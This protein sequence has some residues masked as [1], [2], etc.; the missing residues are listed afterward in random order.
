M[1]FGA[2]SISSIVVSLITPRHHNI[3]NDYLLNHLNE[4]IYLTKF[5]YL[6]HYAT[7]KTLCP[8][9]PIKC[10]LQRNTTIADKHATS[11]PHGYCGDP[12]L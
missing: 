12:R 2:L 4:P 3:D 7:E 5:T 10:I 1:F 6:D 9:E 8:E 11:Y